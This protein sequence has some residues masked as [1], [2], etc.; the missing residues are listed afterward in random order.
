MDYARACGHPLHIAWPQY[1]LMP[2]RIFM[3]HLAFQQI[4]DRFE[5]AM[6]MVRRSDCFAWRVGDR[7]HFVEKKKG[8]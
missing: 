4:R 3:F 2:C 8:V 6:G 7:S 5:S 1:A